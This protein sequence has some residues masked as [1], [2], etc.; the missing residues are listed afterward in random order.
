M[1]SKRLIAFTLIELLVVIAIVGI[2]SGFVLVSLNSA[3]DSAKNVKTKNDLAAISRAILTYH[4]LNNA[5]PIEETPCS[6]GDGT[7][8]N[9][10]VPNHIQSFPLDFNNSRYQYSSDGTSYTLTGNL[11]NERVLTYDS[12]TGF[13]E[14]DAEQG[15][16]GYAKRQPIT[17]SNNAEEILTDY[18]IMI[19]LAYDS[20]MQVDF[21]DIRFASSTGQ[22]FSYY[23]ESKTDGVSATFWVKIPEIPTSGNTIY[24]YYGNESS[25][26]ESN[27]ENTF[28]LYENFSESTLNTEKWFTAS[29]RGNYTISSNR[30]VFNGT[31]WWGCYIASVEKFD[32]TKQYLLSYSAYDPSN[33][34][35]GCCQRNEVSACSYSNTV[36]RDTTYYYLPENGFHNSYNGY[37]TCVILDAF[38]A[39]STPVDK[40]ERKIINVATSPLITQPTFNIELHGADY[41]SKPTYYSHIFLSK[42]VS[43]PPTVSLG[44]EEVL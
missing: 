20:D 33:G 44:V 24:V 40:R 28:L 11:T 10:L 3:T 9:E 43:S 2:L 8:L 14:S 36:T 41:Y 25:S 13:S 1:K 42:Y 12:E 37:E 38:S 15:L 22:L 16:P 5:Y 21:D 31:S 19:D 7:C 39:Y 6:I 23:L 17:I 4:A 35:S 30:I 27:G 29:L 26:S 18:Q 34:G 32:K